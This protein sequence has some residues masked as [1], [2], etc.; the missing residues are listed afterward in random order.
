MLSHNSALLS[1]PQPELLPPQHPST[2]AL[3]GSA[4]QTTSTDGYVSPRQQLEKRQIAATTPPVRAQNQH[5][6]GG[7]LI[8]SSPSLSPLQEYHSGFSDVDVGSSPYTPSNHRRQQ[9]FP[10]LL[11][12]SFRSRTP[13]PTRK[14]SIFVAEHQQMPFTG[15]GRPTTGRA[16]DSSPRGGFAGWLSGTAA[17]NALGMSSVN[18][19][20]TSSSL[21]SSSASRADVLDP[22]PDT[23]PTR[24]RRSLTSASSVTVVSHDPATP[25]NTVTSRFMSAISSRFTPAPASPVF[26]DE[27][28]NL[29]IESALFPPGSPGQDSFSPAAFKNLQAN[30]VGLLNKMQSAYRERVVTLREIQAERSAQRDE[31]EEAETRAQHLKMQL[32]GMAHRAQE[33]EKMM[34]SLMEELAAEKRARLEDQQRMLLLAGGDKSPLG[35]GSMVSEDLGVDEDRLQLKLQRKQWRKSTGSNG[36]GGVNDDTD[37][38]SA[39]SESVFSRCRSPTLASPLAV[40]S[41]G[42]NGMM[43]GA[44]TPLQMGRTNA[45]SLAPP[46]SSQK[47]SLSKGSG[48]SALQKI[49]RGISGENVEDSGPTECVNCK[50]QDASVAWDTVSLLRDENRHLKQRVGQLEVAVEGALDLVNGI[51]M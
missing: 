3:R 49:I 5:H 8:A 19:A 11:P 12:L 41:N 26:D 44:A 9:S 39:E 20:T 50:G 34:R 42:E 24:S 18:P 25:K 40:N 32:E 46:L 15:D 45:S 22:T 14:P 48:V 31:M 13:S 1:S 6:R 47:Q 21:S 10:N 28:C 23:T 43:D 27:L 29:D 33:Q 35:E 36:G 30:A 17:G 2:L 38:E 4:N 7:S 51:G 37:E 16:G